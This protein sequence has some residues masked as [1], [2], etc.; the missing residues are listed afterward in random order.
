[1][2]FS[3]MVA[4]TGTVANEFK[5]GS[6]DADQLD[7]A[8]GN[9]TLHGLDGDDELRGG[10]G[11]DEIYGWEGADQLFGGDG[12][13]W[14]VMG[15]PDFYGTPG[16]TYG[17]DIADG[18][19]DVDMVVISWWN[20]LINGVATSITLDFGDGNF[21]VQGGGSDWEKATN[22]EQL[23]Y[24]GSEGGDVIT[25][26]DSDD[27]FQLGGGNDILRAKGGDD[28]IYDNGGK[29]DIDAGAGID[30]LRL[31]TLTLLTSG[32]TFKLNSS[33]IATVGGSLSGTV[34]NVD[35]LYIE[36]NSG[37]SFAD[38][39]TGGNYDDT[40]HGGAG[41]DTIEGGAGNDELVGQAGDDVIRGGAGNDS[42]DGGGFLGVNPN[43]TGHDT[44][45]G[46]DGNDALDAGS[47]GSTMRGGNGNDSLAGGDGVDIMYG[48]AGNDG[49]YGGN[50]DDKIYGGDGDDGIRCDDGA[51]RID[52]GAGIDGITFYWAEVDPAT[53]REYGATADLEDQSKNKGR[54][55]VGDIYI[56]IE[57]IH[58]TYNGEDTLRG[59]DADNILDGD[60]NAD[61]LEGRG[62]AD[63]LIGGPGV[64]IRAIDTA[65]YLSA[66]TGVVANLTSPA[67]NT[68]DA[69]GDT[70]VSIENLEG[71]AFSD[72]LTGNAVANVLTGLGGND[73]LASGAGTDHLDGGTG[74]DSMDG[75][76]DSDSYIVDNAA[77]VVIE[78]VGG[79]AADRVS[80]R[81]SYG[82][83]AG[84]EVELLTTT[85]S[86][87]T[88]AI[89]LAGNA[90]KQEIT[91]NAGVNTLRDGGG[92]GDVLR[93]MGANDTYLVYSGATAIV[94]TASQGAADRVMAAVDYSLGKGVY[95]EQLTTTSASGTSAIDLTGNAL[96]QEIIGNAGANILHDG[97][98]GAT[99]TLKGLGGNDTYLI[100]NSGDLIVEGAT[101][102]TADRIAAAV[103]YLLGA[104]VHVEAM[105][106]TSLTGT[107]GIDLTGN[108]IAQKITGNA[109]S[110]ILDGK[111]GND[112]L[113]SGSGKDFFVFSTKLGTGSID[114]VTDFNVADDTVRLEN[115]I[116]T[117][118][119]T[120]G[121]LAASAFRANATGL[122]G[123]SDDRIIY[124]TDTGKLFYDA[125]GSASGDS[126]HFATLTIGLGLTSADFVV[127]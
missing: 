118:L 53:L 24:Y 21:T 30:T 29:F 28:Y 36:W 22:F 41:N 108:E 74:A 1:M 119:T 109:G 115:A 113:T 62:G 104:G 32:A 66:P 101:Q 51:D 65:S 75:G 50:G 68:G 114:T 105:Q 54:E 23:S 57:N 7:G 76:A 58:G 84:A 52:G 95:V 34:K 67:G 42:I 102:G 98:A 124:E 111:G 40:I 59:N 127:V 19:N 11:D 70:Y 80:A 45:Y 63:Q 27:F 15:R 20:Q 87:G 13:D 82:L 49:F 77:D 71:S 94:E 73:T 93:G 90:L 61:I 12:N 91:G 110:N 44:L 37:T 4:W 35:A 33:G 39:F 38:F 46:D 25:G 83:A 47:D 2:E 106:T 55:A 64:G 16:G 78:A 6:A 10:A 112:T 9:D 81:A 107:S 123:D 5:S 126:I 103:D 72:K 86:G 56:S 97:G 96:K 99:D 18:G 122:A 60:G 17:S 14:I 31:D 26:G 48:D 3:E 8:G 120:T 69:K 92:V 125:N 117:A 89:D 100:Y 79:G 85:S 116:F 88:T 43:F 121:A